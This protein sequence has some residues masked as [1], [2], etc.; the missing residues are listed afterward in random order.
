MFKK[1]DPWYQ[2]LR[3]SKPTAQG[4]ALCNA[5]VSS[6]S[7]PACTRLSAPVTLWH[8][9][10]ELPRARFCLVRKDNQAIKLWCLSPQGR[11][12]PWLLLFGF[13]FVWVWPWQSGR[14]RS[15][16][17]SSVHGVDAPG[18]RSLFIFINR[19]QLPQ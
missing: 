15:S 8:N 16:R 18:L 13:I 10:N 9:Q 7:H 3:L 5:R 11:T 17:G 14:Q 12:H 6:A 2:T 1:S 19:A 4:Q